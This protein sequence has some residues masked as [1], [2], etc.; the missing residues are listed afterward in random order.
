MKYLG[1]VAPDARQRQ[2][3]SR[4]LLMSS[5]SLRLAAR[6]LVGILLAAVLMLAG[7]VYLF[8]RH[9]QA[10]TA[11]VLEA[12]SAA[13]GLKVEAASV[14]IVL[15][16]I[17]AASLGDVRIHGEGFQL[18]VAYATLRPDFWKLLQGELQ[19]AH[20]QLLRPDL[21]GRIPLDTLTALPGQGQAGPPSPPGLPEAV[22]LEIQQGRIDATA[23]DGSRL[24]LANLYCRLATGHGGRLSGKASWSLLSLTDGEGPVFAVR[25]VHLDGDGHPFAP[26]REGG[27]LRVRGQLEYGDWLRRLSADI[28]WQGRGNAWE[29]AGS[30]NGNL[31]QNG[32]AIPFALDG[33]A[34]LR[35]PDAQH[36]ELTGLR[37]ALA[38]DNGQ[39]D[40]LLALAAPDGPSLSGQLFMNRLS[41]TR[42][43]GF[44]RDLVPGLRLALDNITHVSAEFQLDAAGLR[45]PAISAHCSG[46]RFV[47]TGGVP[48]WKTP[49]VTLEL[50]AQH[51]NLGL[52][53]PEAVGKR[54]S[55]PFFDHAP[56]TSFDPR[57][58][59][60]NLRSQK[61]REEDDAPSAADDLG[62]DIQLSSLH[63]LYGPLR[64]QNARVRISPGKTAANGK[65]RAR[66][67]VRTD[68][69]GGTAT[70]QATIG[71]GGDATEFDIAA[72]LNALQ[73]G[74]LA[75]D[76]PALPLRGGRLQAQASL[77]SRGG[78]IPS[79]LAR[80]SGKADLR[81]D[82]GSLSGLLAKPLAYT[83]L[84]LNAQLRQGRWQQSRVGL[85]GDWTLQLNGRQVRAD[86]SLTGTLW[87]G[88]SRRVSLE[89]M[90]SRLH[91]AADR[92]WSGLPEGL[93]LDVR[94]RLNA[95]AVPPQ[96][97]MAHAE[98]S[99]LA[100]H[101]AGSLQLGLAKD[102]PTLKG[103][104]GLSCDDMRRTLALVR[105][106]PPSLPQQ[107]RALRVQGD[108]EYLARRFSLK[109]LA[110]S[111]LNTDIAGELSVEARDVPQL[112]FALSTPFFDVDS[113]RRT[114]APERA[115][116]D[117]RREEAIRKAIAERR[118]IPPPPSP[119]AGPPWDL[120]FLK[121][122]GVDG[123]LHAKRMKSWRL[124]LT[125]VHAP[126]KLADGQMT[127]QITANL[128][129][130]ILRSSGQA[131]FDRG[132][133][134]SNHL[135]AD[136]FD[137]AQASAERGGDARVSGRASLDLRV[138][139]AMNASG[140]VLRALDGTWKMRVQDGSHQTLQQGRA[141]DKPTLFSLLAASG[142]IRQ[143][144]ARSGDLSLKAPDMTV[145]G[146]GQIN[147][148]NETL[149]C[150]LSVDTPTMDNIPV[151]V[152]GSLHDIKTSISA[153]TVLLYAL[154]GLAQGVT[155]LVGGLLD[156]ALSLFR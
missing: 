20:V 69:Y 127:F 13:T 43:L 114:L 2:A 28:Q 119:P 41:L 66:L 123:S 49:V 94:G 87:L 37:F 45:V 42:W 65:G 122:F 136:G 16:P 151:R 21:A 18:S 63:L 88:G 74:A 72:R 155:G 92:E 31:M 22:H 83:S 140:Q 97:R 36:V 138:S 99:G 115:A 73:A 150:Q 70:A 48:S 143:G 5:R 104:G 79:F 146:S 12:F 82:N 85:G 93:E 6:V 116:A 145:R 71:G 17:P 8:Q 11:H 14:D 95:Q 77:R 139:A 142:N 3:K 59:S 90:D 152:Y 124:T 25:S 27:T 9:S 112:R 47:G 147:L 68:L 153:G 137:L 109:K 135:T 98:V 62:Y 78:D 51:V 32:C 50:M 130:A 148:V 30:L 102:G 4:N 120:R 29:L 1:N 106:N 19:P 84:G 15:L 128:Y 103:S 56:L 149:E 44:A 24:L 132:M 58:G 117:A 67:D 64:M 35:N 61:T 7:G 154:S 10:L 129:G 131:Q 111:L 55:G 108:W 105:E 91:L 121:T 118:A 34:R 54:P 141:K 100:A 80:L 33:K 75:E 46:S 133:R 144:I 60:W 107:L 86:G 38:E 53:I 52:A 96:L 76:L 81:A 23:R 89:D 57:P 110:T 156:G 39:L 26:L 101:Y 125:D 40:G 126:V 134:F 113:L